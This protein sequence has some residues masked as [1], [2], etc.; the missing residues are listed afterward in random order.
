MTTDDN[1][2]LLVWVMMRGYPQDAPLRAVRR[3][4][5]FESPGDAKR[6]RRRREIAA[7]IRKPQAGY[8]PP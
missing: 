3:A 2:G 4:G 8:P 1:I 7:A 6:G 5:T